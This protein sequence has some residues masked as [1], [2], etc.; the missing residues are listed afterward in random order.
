V[1]SSLSCDE[2]FRWPS[3]S[4]SSIGRI[5]ISSVIAR[6]FLARIGSVVQQKMLCQIGI[7]AV[8]PRKRVLGDRELPNDRMVVC[9]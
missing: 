9:L 1:I 3:S 6:L 7:A 2:R 5:V 4:A 8:A